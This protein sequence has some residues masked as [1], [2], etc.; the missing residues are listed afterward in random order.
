MWIPGAEADLVAMADTGQLVES[1]W[2]ELKRELGSGD[3][4]NRELAKDLG[5]MA[6]E[7]ALRD[8][9][10]GL[11]LFGV[12][13]AK[14]RTPDDPRSALHPVPLHGLSERVEQIAHSRIDP[15]LEV[16]PRPI[17]S[18]A[19]PACGYLAV[20]VPASRQAPHMVNNR[21]PGRGTTTTRYLSEGDVARLYHRRATRSDRTGEVLDA[22][23]ALDPV[24]EPEHQPALGHLFVVAVPLSGAEAMVLHALDTQPPEWLWS[25][26]A[27]TPLT[28]P[29]A[30][31][32][33]RLD[34]WALTGG[35]AAG[36]HLASAFVE[37]NLFEVEVTEEGIIRLFNGRATDVK[38]GGDA[39]D[40]TVVLVARVAE[41]TFGAACAAAKVAELLGY[42]G[43]WGLG[44]AVTRL[45]GARAWTDSYDFDEPV[46]YPYPRYRKVIETTIGQLTTNPRAV[47]ARLLRP[48]FRAG[49]LGPHPWWDPYIELVKGA[50]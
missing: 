14:G 40:S 8:R 15:P 41:L 23:I 32:S 28:V 36:R 4:P 11:V 18:Q 29:A 19:D 47:V 46:P 5:A 45:K 26:V 22:Y 30:T 43:S 49:H 1:T 21:Y 12:V 3:A 50:Q 44:V 37:K 34:G 27:G 7:S 9:E 2:L 48:L 16:S 38:P 33:P 10:G 13:D 35:F 42:S 6:N 25:L 39:G 17:V 31:Y 24:Q 20:L